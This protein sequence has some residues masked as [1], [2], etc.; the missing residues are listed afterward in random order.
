[1]LWIASV[2]NFFI[3]AAY[4]GTNWNY[5]SF[6]DR[7]AS[8]LKYQS[9][10]GNQYMAYTSVLLRPSVDFTIQFFNLPG[11]NEQNE[12]ILEQ[13]TRYHGCKQD[14]VYSNND[15]KCT[16]F[17]N[18]DNNLVTLSAVLAVTALI[19]GLAYRQRQRNQ[20]DHNGQNGAH[21]P[22]YQ[23]MLLKRSVSFFILKMR[24]NAVAIMIYS[25]VNISKSGTSWQM[26]LGF[27]V[28]VVVLAYYLAYGGLTLLF[29][30][31]LNNLII[32][33]RNPEVRPEDGRVR[34]EILEQV[35]PGEFWS[36]A[37]RQQFYE[38]QIEG[39]NLPVF[40]PL[41]LL[42]RDLMIS[43]TVVA[44]SAWIPFA[45][46]LT[47]GIE[48]GFLFFITPDNLEFEKNTTKLR[49]AYSI[50][51]FISLWFEI[52][53][54]ILDLVMFT[55]LISIAIVGGYRF[56]SMV[57]GWMQRL[58]FIIALV[59]GWMQRLYI[60]IL[61]VLNFAMR[62]NANRDQAFGQVQIPEAERGQPEPPGN[63]DPEQPPNEQQ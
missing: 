34:E 22:A 58:F 6:I 27:A 29:A 30:R 17:E 5:A 41:H 42:F 10:I 16:I 33:Q 59:G 24:T 12:G 55:I 47:L 53:P 40:F 38:L 4:A 18:M 36:F 11:T 51:A 15:V 32:A 54:L 56:F 1:M 23:G 44:F 50:L 62:R 3:S 28:S 20:G 57:G 61:G 9:L 2:S 52:T 39:G 35:Y 31:R 43:F 63:I 45:N 49:I 48:I 7:F 26:L 14:F 21:G 46:L 8:D 25:W 37:V 60:I 13:K 19:S